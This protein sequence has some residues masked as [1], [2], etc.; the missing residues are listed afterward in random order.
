ML[1]QVDDPIRS[2]IN[3]LIDKNN[4]YIWVHLSKFI[5][6]TLESIERS[7]KAVELS[8]AHINKVQ[9]A[10]LDQISSVPIQKAYSSKVIK[11]QQHGAVEIDR[12]S[13][14]DFIHKFIPAIK[15]INGYI[16][17]ILGISD[18]KR[19]VLSQLAKIRNEVNEYKGKNKADIVKEFNSK[20]NDLLT[21]VK[22]KSYFETIALIKPEIASI[23]RE[24]QRKES[25]YYAQFRFFAESKRANSSLQLRINQAEAQHQKLSLRNVFAVK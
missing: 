9:H 13:M 11:R 16:A 14:I 19:E 15:D 22:D 21:S 3:E 12:D 4:Y 10:F 20:V 17:N 7:A 23:M 5:D 2:K 6:D 8:D 24:L 1:R 25:A 18:Q